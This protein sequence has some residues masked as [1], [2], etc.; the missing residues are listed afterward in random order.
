MT[1]K[2]SDIVF[3][4]GCGESYDTTDFPK[5]CPLECCGECGGLEFINQS[6]DIEKG[7]LGIKHYD[8]LTE[9]LPDNL[10]WNF[11]NNYIRKFI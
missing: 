9:I 10:F 1:F 7:L 8:T 4:A 2:D 6:S 5:E 3:Y 11:H